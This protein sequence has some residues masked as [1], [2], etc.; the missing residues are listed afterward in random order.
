M[1]PACYLKH[2]A[3]L[4]WR[5]W[6]L[7]P[8][9]LK[10]ALKSKG[11][12]NAAAR[13]NKDKT[14][15]AEDTQS[16]LWKRWLCTLYGTNQS[17]ATCTCDCSPKEVVPYLVLL[18]L[19]PEGVELLQSQFA[20]PII[21]LWV[22][23]I[24]SEGRKRGF[25]SLCWVYLHVQLWLKKNCKQKRDSSPLWRTCPLSRTHPVEYTIGV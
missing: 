2:F 12:F 9:L 13:A 7:H 20:T 22:K 16:L 4:V 8:F 3:T 6:Y 10:V 18:N 23:E 21:L 17:T 15:G 5:T 11:F 25:L 14:W 19:C 1:Q 24:S